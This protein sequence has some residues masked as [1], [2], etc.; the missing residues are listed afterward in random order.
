MRKSVAA[1]RFFVSGALALTLGAV[2]SQALAATTLTYGSPLPSTHVLNQE[3]IEPFLKRLETESNGQLRWRYY[4]GGTTAKLPAVMDSIKNGV[5]D[6][7]Y[8]ID[9]LTLAE[10]SYNVMVSRMGTYGTDAMVMAGAA[11]EMLLLHCEQCVN[12]LNRQNIVPLA[13]VATTPF[14]LVCRDEYTD[15]EQMRGKRFRA[16][17]SY[18]QIASIW[19]GVPVNVP[20]TDMFEALQ[21]GQADCTFGPE[22]H[23]TNYSL[24]E[25]AKYVVDYSFGMYI[26]GSVFNMNKRRWE[27]LPAAGRELIL[28]NLAAVVSSGVR[29]YVNEAQQARETAIKHGMTYMPP[30]PGIVAAVEQYRAGLI[31][32]IDEAARARGITDIRPIIERFP[33]LIEKW[34]GIVK[35][36]GHDYDKFE[37]ALHRE[38]FSH[39]RP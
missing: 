25:V 18:G 33:A 13:Y 5:V 27:S 4:P 28:N 29:A 32:S 22:A 20:P 1:V 24:Y 11:N 17:G 21:R 16:P 26:S 9:S 7:G 6:A 38:I 37:Q 3:V 39:Y 23:I 19:G 10:Q 36:I 8:M 15:T 12:Q 31:D 2:S 14:L 35:E 30:S 34:E